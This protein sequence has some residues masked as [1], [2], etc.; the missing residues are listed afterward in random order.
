MESRLNRWLEPAINGQNVCV[1]PQKAANNDESTTQFREKKDILKF[2]SIF[3]H[4]K[5]CCSFTDLI[6]EDINTFQNSTTSI[7]LFKQASVK[8]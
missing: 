6:D 4:C 1:E 7:H 2:F 8:W 3:S 5:R